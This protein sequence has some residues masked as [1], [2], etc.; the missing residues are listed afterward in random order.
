MSYVASWSGG[1]DSCFA[2]H[3]AIGQ[4]YEIS[5]LANFTNAEY[6]RVRFHGT[7]A[8]LIQLQAE[9]IGI[10]L[11][12]TPTTWPGTMQGRRRLRRG[13]GVSSELA[14]GPLAVLLSNGS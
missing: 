14:P 10:P 5:H 12:Q 8:R 11:V 6:D 4:G 7:E 9:A 13:P 1:K 2:C 3:T